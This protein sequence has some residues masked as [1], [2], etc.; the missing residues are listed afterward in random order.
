MIM[1]NKDLLNSIV[2]TAQM[3][4][5]GIRSVLKCP[6]RADL[7]TALRSQLDEYD[8]IEQSA[9]KIAASKGWKL[10]ELNPIVKTMTNFMTKTRLT[11]GE[12]NS[13]AA[14]MMIQGN[15]RG[16]IKGYKNLHHCKCSDERINRLQTTL[17]SREEENARQMQGF[18]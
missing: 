7:K 1:D 13:R 9:M 14:A 12:S 15:T 11:I 10:D 17:L 18:L 4:Q 8:K 3:G 2:K 6:L 5:I 16:L